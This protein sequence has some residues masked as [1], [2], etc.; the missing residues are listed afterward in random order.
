VSASKMAVKLSFGSPE[1][2]SNF[3]LPFCYPTWQHGRKGEMPVK[4]PDRAY[5][6]RTLIC[7]STAATGHCG[8]PAFTSAPSFPRSRSSSR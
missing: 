8:Q 7:G 6:R 1:P 4:A 3:L 5:E 2:S